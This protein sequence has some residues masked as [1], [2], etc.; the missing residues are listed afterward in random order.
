MPVPMATIETLAARLPVTGYFDR[1][2]ARPGETLEAKV[3]VAVPGPVRASLLRVVSGDANPD[4]P[5]LVFEDMDDIFAHEFTGAAQPIRIGSYGEAALDED[6]VA[7][8][9]TLTALICP[10]AKD[11]GERVILHLGDGSDGLTLLHGPGGLIA[12]AA[13]GGSLA[14]VHD[15]TPLERGR[16]HRVWLGFDPASGRLGC[17][18]ASPEHL[19][20]PARGNFVHSQFAGL[21]ARGQVL[22]IAMADPDAPLTGFNGRIEDPAVLTGWTDT[23]EQ[24]MATLAELGDRLIAG[25]DLSIGIETQAITDIGPGACHGALYNVPTRAVTGARWTGREHCWR[26]APAEYAAIRFHDDDLGDIGWDTAFTFTVPD[27]MRSGAYALKLE[28]EGGDD[29]LPF[30]VLPARGERCAPVVFLASTYTYMAYGN[31]ARGNTDDAYRQRAAEWGARPYNP[32]DYPIYGRSTYNL[33]RDGS[34]I[35]Q[36]SRARPL[37]TMRPGFMTFCDPRGS[38]LRHYPADTHLLAWLDAKGIAF[39]V[40]T[41]EDLDNE[42]V[43]LLDGCRLLLT[44]THPEYHT[45]GTLDALQAHVRGGGRMCYLGGNGFYWRIGRDAGRPDGLEMRRAEGGTRAWAEQPGEYYHMSDGMLGGLWKRARRDPQQLAGVGFSSQGAFEAGYFR[46]TEASHDES[47]AWMFEGIDEE[48]LGDYG[49]NAGGAAGFELDRAQA[50]FGTPA[51]AVVVA[52]TDGLTANFHPAIEDLSFGPVALGGGDPAPLV[53]GDMT[54]FETHDG[55][56]VFSASAI[57]FCGSLWRNGSFGGPV[58][59]LMENVV[60]HLSK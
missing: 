24:P 16:W 27:A 19:Y 51:D 31:H 59:Q 29:Y 54:Y 53:R 42:G 35:S 2:S 57:T 32:D 6:M 49:L 28:C 40:V 3:S 46:R 4:G 30:Y 23:F 14:E 47:L 34:G 48:I 10:S 21:S 11:D 36:V 56:A 37:L 58:S 33:H 44:G 26:H 20:Q 60:N 41:D 39:D 45:A 17:G 43:S 22:R 38:G 7:G 1:F 5:G 25:Y 15:E 8:A 52:T 55:G 9:I 13:S 18:H 50:E 12:R